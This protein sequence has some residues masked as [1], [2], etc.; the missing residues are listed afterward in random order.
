M[1]SHSPSPS[2]GAEEL[3]SPLSLPPSPAAQRSLTP[4]ATP[5]HSSSSPSALPLTSP[6]AATSSP[7]ASTPLPPGPHRA[8]LI[9]DI[10][11]LLLSPLPTPS[12]AASILV[13]RQW[14]NPSVREL[15]RRARRVRG[16]WDALQLGDEA[17]HSPAKRAR[18]S[19][20]LAHLRTLEFALSD[21]PSYTH[22]PHVLTTSHLTSLSLRPLPSLTSLTFT[23]SSPTSL[24]TALS[25]ARPGTHTIRA[26]YLTGH[27]PTSTIP[28]LARQPALRELALL[29]HTS[30]DPWPLPHS[31]DAC[32]QL[33]SLT[34][35]HIQGSPL[36]PSHLSALGQMQSLET[37]ILA[38]PAL[39]TPPEPHARPPQLPGSTPGFPALKTVE[40]HGGPLSSVLSLLHSLPSPAPLE[41]MALK[42]IWTTPALHTLFLRL[43]LRARALKE[44]TLSL[45][46]GLL[47]PKLHPVDRTAEDPGEYTFLP[48]SSLP[49]LR[50]L[51]LTLTSSTPVWLPALTS[52]LL[53]TLASSLKH[54]RSLRL[55]TF[56]YSYH[57]SSPAH[58]PLIVLA[59]LATLAAGCKDLQLLQVEFALP[60]PP[61][62][63]LVGFT[64]TFS[65][66]PGTR[67]LP[68]TLPL[69]SLPRTQPHTSLKR[70][71]ISWS[72]LPPPPS[73]SL[74]AAAKWTA[75]LFPLARLGWGRWGH[76]EADVPDGVWEGH[77]G[78]GQR[79]RELAAHGH[80]R[81]ER[82]G[83][84]VGGEGFPG[85]APGEG[86]A[87]VDSA[88]ERA[89]AFARE[90]ER[91]QRV[92]KAE[93]GE[94]G[95]GGVLRC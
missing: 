72:R 83:M 64:S 6:P 41:H 48:L 74:E 85:A 87:G 31:L 53:T 43:L 38:H 71:L 52:S 89:G 61:A 49:E 14:F 26:L 78:F 11:D 90:V 95:E 28:L 34:R 40:I 84:G 25:L 29:T 70:L 13:C 2:P 86:F 36:L 55:V 33:T 79:E 12:L 57:Y 60:Y 5:P 92:L 93:E 82:M 35:L 56:D 27:P 77:R 16:V 51:D 15:W 17:T 42:H 20:Y 9:L 46:S 62:S 69:P 65:S 75:A 30:A 8:L 3:A 19:S 66:G 76:E 68:Y 10:L 81:R 58:A 50:L 91:W 32:P 45:S 37:L 80:G 21:D 4:S 63:A 88:R 59:D 44:L 23:L 18:T 67:Y 1:H 94:G 7:L 24:P 39:D 22:E 54:L 47:H 73:P